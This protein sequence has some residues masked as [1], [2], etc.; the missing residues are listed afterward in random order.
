MEQRSDR[1]DR[2]PHAKALGLALAMALLL[3]ASHPH[4]QAGAPQPA[5]APDRVPDRSPASFP[6]SSS[7]AP[8]GIPAPKSSGL[9]PELPESADLG[10]IAAAATLCQLD[11]P[12]LVARQ[13]GIQVSALTWRARG[14]REVAEL[15]A[16]FQAGYASFSKSYWASTELAKSRS[17]AFEWLRWRA[18]RRASPMGDA[19]PPAAGSALLAA[20]TGRLQGWNWACRE[21]PGWPAGAS[22]QIARQAS[23]TLLFAALDSARVADLLAAQAAWSDAFSKASQARMDAKGCQALRGSLDSVDEAFGRSSEI[24]PSLERARLARVKLAGD[25]L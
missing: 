6:P 19:G 3:P 24:G 21:S 4:P 2:P 1:S 14:P 13:S 25:A 23:S 20:D 16:A 5:S 17:C 8:D 22:S 9:S 7:A 10:S 18:L 12:S 11:D 15:L